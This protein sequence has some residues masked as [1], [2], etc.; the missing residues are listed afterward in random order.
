MQFTPEEQKMIAWLRRQHAAWRTTRLIIL[1]ASV[2]SIGTAA[3]EFMQIG[4]GAL[5]FLFLVA[6][7][8]GVSHTLGCWSWRPEVSLLLKLV[9]AEGDKGGA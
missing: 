6:G 9:E 2:V 7:T 4:W 5:Q 3:W 1:I 8:A